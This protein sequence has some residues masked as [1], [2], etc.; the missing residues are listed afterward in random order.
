M[1]N[2]V[3]G[4]AWTPEGVGRDFQLSK[5]LSPL[6][7]HKD[8]LLVLSQLWNAASKKGD[9]HYVKTAGFLTGTDIR[10]DGGLTAH[11]GV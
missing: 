1:P 6:A 7:A 11:I 9:G 2:G 8:Q 5:T 10:I 3:N 4:K